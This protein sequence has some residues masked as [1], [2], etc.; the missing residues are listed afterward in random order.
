MISP[1]PELV[2]TNQ[3]FKSYDICISIVPVLAAGF[4]DN[5]ICQ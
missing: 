5:F 3:L 1:L 2:G 4:F